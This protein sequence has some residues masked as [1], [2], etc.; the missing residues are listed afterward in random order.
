MIPLRRE[1]SVLATP[2]SNPRMIAKALASD[3]DLVMLDLEDAVAP[4]QKPAARQDVAQAVCDGDWRGRPRLVR[5]NALGTPWFHRDLIDV[6]ESAGD[7]LDLLMLPKVERPADIVAVAALLDGIEAALGVERPIGLEAQIETA[8]GLLAVPEIAAAGPRLEA[9][10]FGPGDFAAS[11]RMPLTAIG[12]PDEW[13]ARYPGHRFGYAM[14]QIVV[15]ARAAGRRAIDGPF[16]DV[17][18]P[19]GLRQ[20][21]QIA[22]ALGFDGKWCIHPSQIDSVNE[23]FSP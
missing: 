22:R 4:E 14:H 7:R 6:V 8:A 16:A 9:L 20:S 18:D 10:V 12:A 2:G 1:R 5:V 13:D 15:A 21:A 19:D 17:R 3:A 23:V 11:V